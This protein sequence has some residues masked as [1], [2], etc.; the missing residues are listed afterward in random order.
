VTGHWI[1]ARRPRPVAAGGGQERSW[2]RALL[3]RFRRLSA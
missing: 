2:L 3:E 1:A